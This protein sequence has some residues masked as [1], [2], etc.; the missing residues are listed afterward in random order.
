M[1]CEEIKFVWSSD[2]E[3]IIEMFDCGNVKLV[4]S[5][6]FEEDSVL[7]VNW[8]DSKSIF[9]NECTGRE[10]IIERGWVKWEYELMG[11]WV[12]EIYVMVDCGIV[13]WVL[14]GWF[15]AV[16]VIIDCVKGTKDI[17]ECG[18]AKVL[19]L[20]DSNCDGGN[21]LDWETERIVFPVDSVVEI[22]DCG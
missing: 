19:S 9:G 15:E 21:V 20:N 10:L 11:N 6:E 17:F 7:I 4:L 12:E 18:N 5:S 1:D 3:G 22:F 8:A 2:C 16:V 14:V 13:K